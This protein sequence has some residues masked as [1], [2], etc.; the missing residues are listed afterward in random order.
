MASK[1]SHPG[2]SGLTFFSRVSAAVSH[3]IKNVLAIINEIAGLLDDLVLM[4]EKGSSPS[5][6]RLRRLADTIQN[7][8]KRADGIVKKM[9]RFAHSADHPMEDLDLY[10]TTDFITDMCKRIM[11]QKNMTAT[12]IP[13]ESPVRIVTHPFYLQELIFVCIETIQNK[14]VSLKTI[15]I[16]Y[17]KK[18]PGAEIWFACEGSPE[19]MSWT[20]VFSNE[21]HELMNYLKAELIGDTETVGFRILLPQDL[22]ESSKEQ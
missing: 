8:I 16:E 12:V 20:H 14:T 18:A 1:S 5:P 17:R 2:D 7:Q 22:Y 11:R 3:E 10:D 6:E 21:A 4:S 9:N 19:K 13:P 15:R